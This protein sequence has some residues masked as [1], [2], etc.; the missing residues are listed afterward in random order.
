M[1]TAIVITEYDYSDK[2]TDVLGVATTVAKAEEMVQEYYGGSYKVIK[3]FINDMSINDIYIEL[4]EVLD[5][6]N[7]PYDIS[8]TLTIFNLNELQ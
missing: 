2:E 6:E 3:R 7:Q 1:E 4:A 8:I 5:H